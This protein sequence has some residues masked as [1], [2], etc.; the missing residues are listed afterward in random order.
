MQLIARHDIADYDRWKAAFDAEAETL[1]QAGLSVLQIWREEGA[2]RVFVLYQVNDR[3]RAQA[4]LDMLDS[5]LRDRAGLSGSD[6]HF[7]RTV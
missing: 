7:L 5:L 2:A 6:Y 4:G 1:G 3:A